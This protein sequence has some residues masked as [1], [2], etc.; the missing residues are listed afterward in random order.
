MQT[1]GRRRRPPP[2]R[3]PTGRGRPRGQAS[4]RRTRGRPRSAAAS[5]PDR[6]DAAPPARGSGRNVPVAIGSGVALAALF[7]GSLFWNH[8]VFLGFVGL[9]VVVALIELDIAFRST[10][11]RPATPVAIGAGMVM[12]FGSYAS[13]ASAQS[14]G[15][16]LLVIGTAAWTLADRVGGTTSPPEPDLPPG[17]RPEPQAAAQQVT[18]NLSAT[19]LACLWVPFLASF[20]GLL[21]ARPRGE[22]FL[23]AAVAL[24]VTNDIGA[25]AFGSRFGR[26]TMAPSV[27]PA[28][29]WEGFVGGL[30]V[31]VLLAA[32]ATARVPGF[33][34]D[35]VVAVALGVGMVLA[36]TFGDLT[37]SLIKR[38][39]GVK[40]LGRIIP[41]H[42]GIMDRA[43]A[44]LFALPIAHIVLTLLGR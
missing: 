32:V 35:V 10:G 34:G 41:G 16:V 9:L 12:F 26:H 42:G 28:K 21:L 31:T 5:R 8:W 36:S 38:D 15:L 14:L 1:S 25:F 6:S 40:D 27:S 37:E 11:L 7:I 17:T 43:D 13:G 20:A 33:D 2:G 24:S 29:T 22:W 3:R 39:L 23:L 4:A 44:I 30:A 19:V 18:S